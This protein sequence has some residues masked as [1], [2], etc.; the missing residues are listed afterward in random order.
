MMPRYDENTK[1]FLGVFAYLPNPTN[2]TTT[3]AATYYPIAGPFTNTVIEKFSLGIDY[4]EFTN[5]ETVYVKIVY[6]G[7]FQSDTNNTEI[8][9]AVKLNGAVITGSQSS[10]KLKAAGDSGS[11]S[12]VVVVEITTGDQIQLVLQSNQAG[13]VITAVNYT[14]ALNRFMVM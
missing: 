13:A 10:F 5:H 3:L 4:I 11:V 7:T 14:T 6:S 1:G 9:T 2:T 12:A 8:T